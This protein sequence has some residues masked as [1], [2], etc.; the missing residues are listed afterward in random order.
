MN[1]FLRL[2]TSPSTAV[3]PFPFFDTLADCPEDGAAEGGEG[4]KAAKKE[5]DK[6]KGAH[7]AAPVRDLDEVTEGGMVGAML[8]SLA[9]PITMGSGILG[10]S[11]TTDLA[12]VV[13]LLGGPVLEFLACRRCLAS[14]SRFSS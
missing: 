7:E 2:P 10:F 1:A 11:M 8:D 14:A 3:F 13:A 5:E 6:D 9:T 12:A 4:D